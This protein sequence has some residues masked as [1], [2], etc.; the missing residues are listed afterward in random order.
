MRCRHC[1]APIPD[2]EHVC[3]SCG[4]RAMRHLAEGSEVADATAA[5]A[6]LSAAVAPVSEPTP[7]EDPA[8]VSPEVTAPFPVLSVEGGD[9]AP[10]PRT[11]AAAAGLAGEP[12]PGEPPLAT[13]PAPDPLVAATPV[14]AAAEVGGVVLDAPTAPAVVPAPAPEAVPA[15]EVAAIVDELVPPVEDEVPADAASPLGQA[16]P[17]ADGPWQAMAADAPVVPAPAAPDAMPVSAPVPGEAPAPAADPLTAAPV[18]PDAG[19]ADAVAAAPAAGAH[20][21]QAAPVAPAPD[22]AAAQ[23]PADVP[24]VP[25]TAPLVPSKRRRRLERMAQRAKRRS[26]ID[27]SRRGVRQQGRPHLHVHDNNQSLSAFRLSAPEDRDAW[28][29][30]KRIVA[31][32]LACVL[33]VLVGAG[34][35][36]GTWKAELWGGRT[37]ADVRGMTS[38]D[39]TARLVAEG[40]Q[41]VLDE[42]P[43][44]TAVGLVVSMSPEP[45][46]RAE[47]GTSVT[48]YVGVSAGGAAGEAAG[49]EVGA[50]PGG[51]SVGASAAPAGSTASSAGEA[52]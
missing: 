9:T 32:V 40:F 48:I 44:T 47:P 23:A 12:A 15:P 51:A 2:G 17:A 36:F 20:D 34:V 42:E 27:A 33:V 8:A 24:E 45:G 1:G 52:G 30:R 31:G 19:L 28:F 46:V 39:A 29:R 37:V 6:H 35:A 38:T 21:A 11:V 7:A 3:P 49:Q 41:V 10:H 16:V 14:V 18:A 13:A 26:W 5:P 22:E 4:A 25:A 50:G 43:S